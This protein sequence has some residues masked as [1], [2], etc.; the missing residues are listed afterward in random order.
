VLGVV[1]SAVAQVDSAYE[2]VALVDDYDFFV[3]GPQEDSDSGVVRV[4][5]DLDVVGQLRQFLLAV[6]AVEAQCDLEFFVQQH[7]DFHPALRFPLQQ[8]VES[9]VLP[10]DRRSLHV[11]LGAQP[12]VRDE[13]LFFGVLDGV[14]DGR[15]VTGA[16]HEPARRDRGPQG[17]ERSV[18]VGLDEISGWNGN[19]HGN[20]FTIEIE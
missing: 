16:V 1:P 13:N 20:R 4:P 18:L 2:S 9:P 6:V 11:Y 3:V 7:E 10:A 12:P 17:G 14:G 15:H 19:V 8:L 5:Q